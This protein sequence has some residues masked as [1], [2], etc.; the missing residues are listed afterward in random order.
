MSEDPHPQSL[1]QAGMSWICPYCG[2]HICGC[3][4]CSASSIPYCYQ[5]DQDEDEDDEHAG[6]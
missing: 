1:M 3:D 4:M 5:C 2:P 6:P